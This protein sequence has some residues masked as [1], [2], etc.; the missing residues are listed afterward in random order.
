MTI[1]KKHNF[2]LTFL[3]LTQAFGVEATMKAAILRIVFN[4]LL[5]RSY[6]VQSY[7][8]ILDRKIRISPYI[9]PPID[10][11][12]KEIRKVVD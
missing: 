5:S 11:S 6:A 2:L 8:A 10:P 7:R 4:Y 1:C 3:I 12:L 9:H